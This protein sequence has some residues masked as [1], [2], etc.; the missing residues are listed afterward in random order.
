[1]KLTVDSINAISEIKSDF[2]YEL[3]KGFCKSG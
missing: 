1:M 3:G 2:L